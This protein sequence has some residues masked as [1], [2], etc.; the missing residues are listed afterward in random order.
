MFRTCPAPWVRTGPPDAWAGAGAGAA[1]SGVCG[2]LPGAE[3]VGQPPGFRGASGAAGAGVDA[4]LDRIVLAMLEL[5]PQNRPA[6]AQVLGDALRE[7]A[8]AM[9]GAGAAA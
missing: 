8:E 1:G 2:P 5:D 4:D 7:R 3:A 6:T 9:A